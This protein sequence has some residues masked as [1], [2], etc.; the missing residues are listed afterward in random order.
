MSGWRDAI[1]LPC[2]A[3]SDRLPPS[4]DPKLIHGFDKT[5]MTRMK[6]QQTP[7]PRLVAWLLMVAIIT[8]PN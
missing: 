4:H 6:S 8:S 3:N 5:Q 7:L 2:D 1:Y